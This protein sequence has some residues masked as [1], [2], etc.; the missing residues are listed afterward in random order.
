MILFVSCDVRRYGRLITFLAVAAL[1]HGLI[2]FGVD[3]AEGMPRWWTAAEGPCF[4][5]TGAVVLLAQ[6]R[7]RAT[8]GKE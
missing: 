8:R 2:L 7:A 6:W 5:A 3:V 4:A 1:V